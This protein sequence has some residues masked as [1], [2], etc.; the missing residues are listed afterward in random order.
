MQPI[1]HSQVH[2][3]RHNLSWREDRAFVAHFIMGLGVF[4]SDLPPKWPSGKYMQLHAAQSLIKDG[5]LV[6]AILVKCFMFC[7]SSTRLV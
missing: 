1:K 4:I 6:E 5:V 3:V 2:G 7:Y